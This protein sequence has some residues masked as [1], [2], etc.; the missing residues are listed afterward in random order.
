MTPTALIADDEPL[1][2]EHLASHLARAWA[3]LQLVGQ[4]RNGREAVAMFE[5]LQPQVVFL[6]VHMPG[7]NGIE[8]ARAIGRRA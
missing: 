7:I 5:E 3:E 4:A 2:R 8:A 6:D 1:L